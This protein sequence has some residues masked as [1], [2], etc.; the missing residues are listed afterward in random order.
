MNKTLALQARRDLSEIQASMA[1]LAHLENQATKASPEPRTLNNTLQPPARAEFAPQVP[2]V[3]LAH[4]V[5]QAHWVPKVPQVRK[6]TQA[7]MA[8]LAKVDHQAR[9]A[10]QANQVRPVPKDHQAKMETEAAKENQV[11]KAHQEQRVHQAR[12]EHQD[13]TESPAQLDHRVRTVH[14]A[15]PAS[16]DPKDHR[17]NRARLA[18]QEKTPNTAR[19]RNVPLKTKKPHNFLIL[20]NNVVFYSSLLF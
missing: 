18:A 11:Q 20:K 8:A 6:A 5:H 1:N 12:P 15:K 13:P 7:K 3:R 4:Q 9:L 17:V 2:K 16:R 10:N 14:Q 19:A